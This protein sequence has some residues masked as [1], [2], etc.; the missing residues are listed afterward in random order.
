MSIPYPC[1]GPGPISDLGPGP[2]TITH[3][4]K[5]WPNNS[6]TFYEGTNICNNKNK[7]FRIGSYPY[8]KIKMEFNNW[9]PELVK[10]DAETSLVIYFTSCSQNKVKTNMITY[11][12]PYN[13]RFVVVKLPGN[14]QN[15]S[16][17]NVLDNKIQG[18]DI[19]HYV[20][21]L[22]IDKSMMFNTMDILTIFLFFLL[23]WFIIK[24]SVDYPW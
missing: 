11:N 23:F 17:N 1:P 16:Q 9:N 20:P 8:E 15:N 14:A 13:D 22:D 6:V 3:N 12:N 2:R 7:S 21:S 5:F 19:S 24:K 4:D 18:F 10:I